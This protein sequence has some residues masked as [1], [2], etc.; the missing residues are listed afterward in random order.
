MKN[1]AYILLSFLLVFAGCKKVDKVETYQVEV[2]E[3]TVTTGS[4]EVSIEATYTYDYTLKSALLQYSDN[5]GLE[6][7]VS[8]A[9]Q[10]AG[11]VLKA[12]ATGLK[13]ATAYFYR[14][15]LDNGMTKMWTETGTFRTLDEPIV[16]ELVVTT[17]E[18]SG[19][20]DTCAVCGGEVVS[21]GGSNVIARGVCYGLSENPSLDDCTGKTVDGGGLGTFTSVMTG[22]EKETKYYVRAYATDNDT[23]CYGEQ[24]IFTTLGQIVYSLPTVIT[25]DVDETTVGQYSAMLSGVVTD[26]GNKPVTGCGFWY[27]TGHDTLGGITKPAAYSSGGF[28]L[29]VSDGIEPG[30]TYYARAYA[31]NEIGRRLGNEV[32]FT[33]LSIPPTPDPQV[34]TLSSADVTTSSATIKGRIYY[35]GTEN[36]IKKGFL[37]GT[38][39]N[40][41]NSDIDCTS[42]PDPF[43]AA[44]TGLTQNTTYYYK[45]YATFTGYAQ[46]FYGGIE[47]FRTLIEITEPTIQTVSPSN[48]TT[49]TA[50]SGGYGITDGNSPIIKKGVCWA[51]FENPTLED[52]LGHTENGTGTADFISEVTGLESGTSYYVRAYAKNQAGK[53]GYGEALGLHTMIMHQAPDVTTNQASGITG[54]SATVSGNVTNNYGC[55]IT[56][57]WIIWGD[58]DNT[59]TNRLDCTAGTAFSGTLTGL[60]NEHTYSF[61]AFAKNEYDE[62]GSGGIEH[63]T[64]NNET[65]DV[66]T[67]DATAI[68]TNSATM[69]GRVNDDHGIGITEC[70]FMWGTNADALTERADC[71]PG[72]TFSCGVDGLQPNTNYYFVAYAK[73]N[74][75]L[76]GNGTV[77]QLL[78]SPTLPTVTTA[79]VTDIAQTTA[80]G[81]GNV[82]SDGGA[83]VT[84]RGI[85]WSTSQNPT[86]SNSHTTDG[87]GTGTFTSS[88]TGLTPNTTYYVRAY[89]TNSAGTAY[90]GEYIFETTQLNPEWPDGDLPG[91]FS[92]SATHHVKFSKGNLQYKASTGTW[93]LADKQY[94]SIKEGNSNIS[95][96]YDGWIDLYG[97][98]TS[99]F[100][101]KYPYM[102]SNDNA[103][104]PNINIT[105]TNYDWG[106][107]AT[108]TNATGEW[109]TLT[110]SEWDYLFLTRTNANQK[111]SQGTVNNEHGLIILPD[112][113]ILPSGLNFTANSNDW[114]TNNYTLNQWNQMEMAGAVFFPTTGVRYGTN[115]QNTTGFGGYWATNCDDGVNVD[116]LDFYSSNVDPSYHC[117]DRYCGRSV[118]LIRDVEAF[119]YLLVT[120][121]D[122]SNITSTT[123]TSG[124][125]VTSFGG[126]TVTAR[127]I[128]W[129]TSP[130]PTISDPHTSNG[131]GTGT[132]TSSMTGLTPSTTYY[133]R[134]YATNSAGT[135]YGEQKSFTTQ[136][137][138]TLPT[139]TTNNVSNIAQ[140][141]ATGGGNVTGDGGAAVTARGICWST[142]PN[143]TVSNS[144]TTDGTGT[145]A[146]T[147][148][149]TGLTPNTTYYVRAYATNSAGTSYGEQKSFTT[150]SG[151]GGDHEYVDLGLP[152]GLL[153]ATCNVGADSPEDYGDYFAWGETETKDYYHWST[154]K[155]C[156][157]SYNNFT[158]YCTDSYYGTVDNK[159]VL[160]PEDDAAHANWG[161]G[162]R[163]P[164][165]EEWQEL[166]D[167]TTCTWTTENGVAGRKF[168]SKAD[169][170]K[171]IFLPAAGYRNGTS[172]SNAGSYGLSWSG[173]LL[174]S[175]P[176]IAYSMG[177]YSDYVSPQSNDARYYGLTVRPVRAAR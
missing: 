59:M 57:C 97:F 79:E 10:F 101:D 169:S 32:S 41:M 130:N 27:S 53:T 148:S 142:S 70:W 109:R 126:A 81:G 8:L 92:V 174:S 105:C 52:C 153:W 83:T 159:T 151:G 150:Q 137:N 96:T 38:D 64:T 6:N 26:D 120:T 113:W 171:Y 104:Y 138:I 48:I 44:L 133:V 84:A 121:D 123:A 55:D 82:T 168:T 85:C 69:N 165:K 54:S 71:T 166:Y 75:G 90:G 124:G 61:Q 39:I 14:F 122:I 16:T 31:E 149:M 88:M 156:N 128:C 65:P 13:P 164:T 172:L 158:K 20:A 160:D 66:E 24:K 127:G 58:G 99:G 86:V 116:N 94:I 15:E 47:S 4:D 72:M 154:Y 146:F 118:R 7:A 106:R 144:H 18:V 119:E 28:S 176:S 12:T 9:A 173:S 136:Q 147:S 5:S 155:W 56:E 115:T 50:N 67:L 78:T 91:V 103:D 102:S 80:T 162:W 114:T 117:S 74:N 2:G 29:N 131:T 177:F 134:A 25:N 35:D 157:G 34:F 108:I 167:N 49:T 145:G 63:F 36:P 132:F 68:T 100:N 95:S 87:T 73:N 89:A 152:S 161:G 40:D 140:T 129:S 42:Q 3:T 143:P 141:T 30:T 43:E 37:Y 19:I 11:G 125:M 22:L 170:S 93:K 175:I 111:Y 45:A 76:V 135:A 21:E 60:A 62:T 139:V 46:T 51:T 77:N 1:T 98:G 23:T 33:T 107:Y 112:S 17:A 163:M 110:Q